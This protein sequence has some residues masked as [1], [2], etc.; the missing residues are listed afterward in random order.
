MNIKRLIAAG[1]AAALMLSATAVPAFASHWQWNNDDD[2][3]ITNW[4][5]VK[6]YVTTKADT[7]DNSISGKYV[8]G[9]AIDTGKAVAGTEVL[10]VVNDTTLDCGCLDG[11]LTIKNSAVVKNYVYTK[12]DTGDNSISGKVVGGGDIDTG[13]ATAGSLVQNIVNTTLVGDDGS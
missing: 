1:S 4:A 12:A 9:G 5:S 11:D 8:F 6:N 3:N 2:V 13:D 10:N 7:G